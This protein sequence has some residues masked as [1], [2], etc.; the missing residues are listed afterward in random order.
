MDLE[1]LA[2]LILIAI[3]LSF[4]TFAVSISTGLAI[5][6]LKFQQG[7]R[8]ALVLAVFQGMM[9]FLGWLGGR[10]IAHYVED[11]DHWVAFALLGA[12]GLK[13][14]VDAF[15]KEEEKSFNPLVISVLIGMA[16]ATSIDALVV[17]VTLAFINV[18]IYLAIGIIGFVTFLA[19]ML[20]MLLGKNVQGHFGKKVEIL[21]GL[22]LLGIGTKIL[23][24]HLMA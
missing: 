1:N 9:P 13:M 15:S 8:I 19:S 6:Q 11:Y 23:F 22:I 12:L 24:E 18:N 20:G 4:D 7:V 10:Q 2:E 14:V 21:G 5:N 3:G 16:I 17:G